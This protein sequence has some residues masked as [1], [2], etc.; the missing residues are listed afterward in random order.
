MRSVNRRKNGKS[1]EADIAEHRDKGIK[2][3]VALISFDDPGN[4]KADQAEDPIG[5][6][7]DR[8]A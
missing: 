4:N 7:G 3:T 5:K 6:K 8:N 2:A 1:H